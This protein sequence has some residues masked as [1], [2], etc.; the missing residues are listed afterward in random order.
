MQRWE[1][2][3][4]AVVLCTIRQ[5]PAVWWRLSELVQGSGL[6]IAD[7]ESAAGRLVAMGWLR[8]HAVG[9]DPLR[10]SDNWTYRLAPEV[11][12]RTGSPLVVTDVEAQQAR[13]VRGRAALGGPVVAPY[14]LLMFARV[15]R[16]L[17][18]ME[19]HC[20]ELS[21]A[22]L[23]ARAGV[24]ESVVRRVCGDLV[25][26]GHVEVRRLDRWDPKGRQGT[27]LYRLSVVGREVY[28]SSAP[29]EWEAEVVGRKRPV[30]AG[31][32]GRNDRQTGGG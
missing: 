4:D 24:S 19:P 21:I 12:A 28:L 8:R 16:V 11:D 29:G 1:S 30:G 10:S 14:S 32:A 31:V 23:T 20:E 2:V 7:V 27:G 18:R 5:R 17:L 9:C 22:G 15:V 26:A 13:G 3:R 25:A 6:D